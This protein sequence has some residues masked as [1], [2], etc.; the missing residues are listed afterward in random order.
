MAAAAEIRFGIEG[1]SCGSCV[2]RAER[3][4]T[5]VPGVAAAHV[6]L[7][8]ASATVTLATDGNGQG[9]ADALK[10]AG[11]PARAHD[12][13]LTIDG[14]SCASCVGRVETALLAVP[15]VL[16]AQVNL[17]TGTAQVSTLGDTQPLID[18][19]ARVGY[20]A[21]PTRT[22]QSADTRQADEA[23]AWFRR[24]LIAAALTLPV[25]I[26]EMG[27]HLFPPFHHWIA[28][29]IGTPASWTIQFILTTLVLAGPGREFFI[30]GIPALRRMAPDMNALVVLG[31]GAAWLFSTVALFAPALLPEGTRVVYFEAAA[32]IVTLILLGRWLE[33]RAKSQTGAAIK[34]LIGL[35]PTTAR[36]I[37]DGT[38][39]DVPLAEVLRDDLLLIRPGDRIPTDGQVTEG[40]SYVDESMITGEPIPVEKAVGDALV[41]GTINGNGALTMRATAVGA[42]TVLARIVAMVQDAQGT[43]LPVQ[44]L[45]NRVTL[46]FVPVVIVIAALAVIG[47]LI[48]GP[49]PV[50]SYALVAG[51]SVLIVACPC[52]MGLATPTAIMVGT[53]RAAGLGVLFRQGDALQALSGIDT[54]A[55]DKTGT[56]TM[57]EPS[58]TD[59]IPI[60]GEK[61]DLLRLVAAVE[62]K[63]EHPV[64]RAIV[65]AV[66]GPVP[67]ASDFTAIPGQ[68]LRGTVDGKA[69][70][71]GN[72][73]LMTESGVATDVLVPMADELAEAGKTPVMV[74]I[75]GT[76]AGV[77]GVADTLRPTAKDTVQRLQDQGLRVAMVTGDAV[78]TGMAIGKA[79]GISHV[80]AG[81]LPDGKVDAIR[82][83]QAN[84]GKVAFVGDGINDAPALAAAEV[85]I[86]IGTGTD[87]A[88]ESAD[89]VLMSGDP[90]GVLNALTISR[91]TMRNVKQNLVWAFGYN[92]LLIPV[93]AGVLF[94]LWGVLLSPALAAGAMALSSVLVV[95][96][97]LR[98]RRVRGVT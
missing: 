24:F 30:K 45:V 37:R 11:Y 58:L 82:D 5:A 85:G 77:I 72:A 59:V 67:A 10:A 78:Q 68:G 90:L 8:D 3:A 6:N 2:G 92:V 26:M 47:W 28:R 74:A 73:R 56:L 83:L 43:R 41:G 64:A 42:D 38:P 18:A 63:S 16:T 54:V 84:G 29:T 33:A 66:E 96:N 46:W 60:V 87:V 19:V 31:T 69:V 93:A 9:V 4:L 22:D 12:I 75:D 57:G 94:P 39:V 14:M 95:T 17:V 48:F 34:H 32:V 55:F 76:P 86:A 89:V 25:F 52:A 15:G 51:V 44:D 79:L 53:G 21:A 61:D 65:A 91:A 13:S 97:A 49:A 81:V 70:I 71:V 7:A 88:V 1:M 80:V 27:G 20:R 36:V 50:L 35:R 23:A 40:V 62:A 98:L